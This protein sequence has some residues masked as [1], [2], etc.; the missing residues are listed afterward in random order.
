MNSAV[1]RESPA[2][3]SILFITKGE[4]AASTRYRMSEYRAHWA[5][6]GWTTSH[7]T[8]DGSLRCWTAILPQARRADI[9]V[10]LR[11]TFRFPFLNLLRALSRKL[12]FDFDDAIFVRGSGE[13]STSK[14]A[15]FGRTVAACD[16]VS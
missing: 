8:H 15:R 12:V 16:L 3:R 2:S 13:E 1:D 7:L 5:R 4:R 6:A 14:R 11:R 10:I 9:V